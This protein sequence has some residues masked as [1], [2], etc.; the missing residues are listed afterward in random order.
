MS[1][2][3]RYPRTPRNRSSLSSFP[4]TPSNPSQR[5]YYS[6]I[7]T[8]GAEHLLPSPPNPKQ[9]SRARKGDSLIRKAGSSG[10]LP[11]PLSF[12]LPPPDEYAM[13]LDKQTHGPTTALL[14]K[15]D[16][17]KHSWDPK[18]QVCNWFR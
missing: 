11:D 13:L 3:K 17:S 12:K 5:G 4:N 14:H 8:P 18:V 7:I 16:Y 9:M 15:S 6:D 1:Q 2:Y 10:N